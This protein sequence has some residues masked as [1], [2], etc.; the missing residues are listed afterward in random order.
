MFEVGRATDNIQLKSV[1]L[2]AY[3]VALTQQKA[4]E[5]TLRELAARQAQ[6]KAESERKAAEERARQLAAAERKE[7]KSGHL[8]DVVV[9]GTAAPDEG[10]SVAETNGETRGAS[11]DVAV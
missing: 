2:A 7:A 6:D 10:G 11:V 8:V 1:G 5:E 4:F 3:E 9:S